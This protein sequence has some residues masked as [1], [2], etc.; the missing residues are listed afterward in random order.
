V[1]VKPLSGGLNDAPSAGH[2]AALSKPSA[3]DEAELLGRLRAGDE[4]AFEVLIRESTPHLLEV[5]RRYF[6]CESDAEDAVQDAFLSAFRA[7]DRFEGGSRLSTW[8]HRITINACLMKLRA[9]SRRPAESIEDLLPTF[10]ET[11]HHV[12][13]PT[14]WRAGETLEAAEMRELVRSCIDRLPEPFRMALMLRDI[15]GLETK[16]AAEMLGLTEAALKTRLHRARQAL[17]TLL[18]P[19]MRGA[20]E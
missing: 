2:Q 4:R 8:L 7:I 10:D 17:R 11:G 1:T 18:D 15:E 14:T 19:I 13:T 16:E 20:R 12:R 3:A 9:S 6:R 5:A